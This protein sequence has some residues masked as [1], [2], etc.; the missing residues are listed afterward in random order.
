[1]NIDNSTRDDDAFTLFK[2]LS[3]DLTPCLQKSI[4]NIF[5]NYFSSKRIHEDRKKR[6]LT[7]L[8][9]NNFIDILIYMY[10]V[11]LIDIRCDCSILLKEITYY[12]DIV[13]KAYEETIIPFLKQ[14]LFPDDLISYKI[15]NSRERSAGMYRKLPTSSFNKLSLNDLSEVGFN[16]NPFNKV[17]VYLI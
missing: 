14:H 12:K 9:Q 13:G 15:E 2:I 7:F 1:M 11:A 8:I 17:M 4:I 10:S 5:I 16:G 6:Q 3:L